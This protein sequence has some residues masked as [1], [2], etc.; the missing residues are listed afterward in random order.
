VGI[1]P[2]SFYKHFKS[3]EAL[4]SELKLQSLQDL[5]EVLTRVT[6]GV[7][8]EDALRSFAHAFR[9]FAKENH[10]QY[11]TTVRP[12]QSDPEV[13]EVS[14]RILDVTA[15]LFSSFQFSNDT[16]I[17]QTRFL[18]SLLHGF[19]SLEI[20]GG[21]GLPLSIEKSFEMMLAGFFTQLKTIKIQI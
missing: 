19:I 9:R 2:P 11:L 18:R 14:R 1:Q 4:F 20:A 10:V 6:V 21:F 3:K 13:E 8:G 7:S 17:H 16:L 5:L 12:D 15:R